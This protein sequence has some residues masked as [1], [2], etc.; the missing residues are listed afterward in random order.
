MTV[1]FDVGT[2]LNDVNAI[3][4]VQEALAFYW[5]H[6]LLIKHIH[7]DVSSMVVGS[8]NSK[9]FDLTFEDDSLAIDKARV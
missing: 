6:E 1:D 2:G 8:S 9:V 4:H 7:K 5:H 3:E